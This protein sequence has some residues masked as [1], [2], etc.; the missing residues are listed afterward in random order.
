VV[1][2]TLIPPA[3]T[4]KSDRSHVRVSLSLKPNVWLSVFPEVATRLNSA[5]SAH[6]SL[7]LSASDGEP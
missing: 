7:G 4:V 3:L 6:P 5:V 2:S 1:L